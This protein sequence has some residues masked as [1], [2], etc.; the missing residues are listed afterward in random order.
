VRGRKHPWNVENRAEI[1]G[2]PAGC[3]SIAEDLRVVG[4]LSDTLNARWRARSRST[5]RSSPDL[6]EEVT[7]VDADRTVAT[8]ARP[9]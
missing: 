8:S 6:D 1:R 7:Q 2:A 3:E 9:I 4:V 5:T